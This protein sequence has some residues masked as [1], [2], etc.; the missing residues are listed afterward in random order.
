MYF[1]Y[2]FAVISLVFLI[3]CSNAPSDLVKYKKNHYFDEITLRGVGIPTEKQI[4]EKEFV[5]VKSDS[6][7]ISVYYPY[8]DI[9]HNYYWKDSLWV[10][11]NVYEIKNVNEKCFEKWYTRADSVLVYS[12]HCL[13]D[14]VLVYNALA[15]RHKNFSNGIDGKYNLT[16]NKQKF[17]SIVSNELKLESIKNLQLDIGGSRKYYL[18]NYVLYYPFK[19]FMENG[20]L[21]NVVN[22]SRVNEIDRDTFLT[23]Y[24]EYRYKR[25]IRRF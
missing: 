25:N 12:V 9:L 14:E 22:R 10:R 20:E 6:D 15:I 21:S 4:K 8:D 3:Q 1:K 13:K 5:L 7:L 18:D 24:P 16:L 11:E 2:F 17:D 19:Q 23:K